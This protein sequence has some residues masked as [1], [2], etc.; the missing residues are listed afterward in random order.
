MGS[1]LVVDLFLVAARTLHPAA[2]SAVIEAAS[3]AATEA[4]SRVVTAVHHAV[5]SSDAT[6]AA[7]GIYH[8]SVAYNIGPF[9]PCHSL[10]RRI[11]MPLPYH[12]HHFTR[13]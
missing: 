9:Y 6:I 10:N 12:L 3:M 13:P 4:A 11:I 8:D 5:R 7:S 1:C 2:A